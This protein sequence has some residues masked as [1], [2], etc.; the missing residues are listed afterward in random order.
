MLKLILGV[1]SSCRNRPVTFSLGED[2][3]SGGFVYLPSAHHLLI[4]THVYDAWT[5]IPPLKSRQ[6]TTSQIVSCES[7]GDRQLNHRV[8]TWARVCLGLLAMTNILMARSMSIHT[9][10]HVVT[11][12]STPAGTQRGVSVPGLS[13]PKA[14]NVH[15]SN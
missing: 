1:G 2:Q 3:C 15:D 7:F 4:T 8:K 9:H 5:S 12:E 13:E 11:L 10:V 14:I 6:E